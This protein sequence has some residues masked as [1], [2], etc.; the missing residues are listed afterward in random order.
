MP[1]EQQP[2]GVMPAAAKPNVNGDQAQ[3]PGTVAAGTPASAEMSLEQALTELEKARKALKDTNAESAGRRKRLEELEAAEQA[4]QTASLTETE[5]QAKASEALKQQA[6][7]LQKQMEILQREHQERVI[8]YE[9]ML[10]ASNMGIID[11]DAATKLM[12]WQELEFGEDGTPK[13]IDGVLKKLIKDRP[14]LSK[15]DSKSPGMG[16][17]AQKQRTPLAETGQAT[18]RV[19]PL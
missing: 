18:R 4:R 3:Q 5:K 9:V 17:P 13:N 1:D 2:S 8:R 15:Q 10:K 12:D 7:D 16:T 6:A 19:T 11:L 14:Y